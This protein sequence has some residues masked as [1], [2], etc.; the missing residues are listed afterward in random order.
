MKGSEIT[1][2][3]AL[4]ICAA[5]LKRTMKD[6]KLLCRRIDKARARG[7]KPS[8][9]DLD[10]VDRIER[11]FRSDRFRLFAGD[12][13]MEYLARKIPELRRMVDDGDL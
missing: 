8:A 2:E 5:V 11:F 12:I 4:N 13:D 9:R 3:G 6:Y 1:E 10:E 7:V